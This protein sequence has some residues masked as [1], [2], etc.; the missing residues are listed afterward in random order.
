MENID[1]KDFEPASG[2]SS[3]DSLLLVTPTGNGE[4]VLF[5]LLQKAL[6]SGIT[7]SVGDNGNWFIGAEDT[8]VVARQE[9]EF[10]AGET[11]LEYRQSG[12]VE[13]KMAM[14][15][16]DLAKGVMDTNTVILT[17]EEYQSLVDA[18]E[19]DDDLWY[20]TTGE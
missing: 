13:W 12:T 15:Y 8:G 16:A 18:G 19:V 1:I 14:G 7:P 10:R 11:G 3:S 4:K 6:K 2:V 17:E 5:S 9:L 20:Y